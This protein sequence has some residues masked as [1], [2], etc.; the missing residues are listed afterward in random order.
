[1]RKKVVPALAVVVLALA[2]VGA[3]AFAAGG[4]RVVM[5]DACD[6]AS[7][8]EVIGEGTCIEGGHPSHVTFGEMIDSLIQHGEHP[9]WRFTPL[10]RVVHLG[11]DVQIDNVGGEFHTYS[12]TDEFGGGFV[13]ELNEILGLD[14]IADGCL[15]PPGPTNAFV[16]AQGMGS[17]ST[18][19]L[20]VGT[21]KFLC[22][23][24]PWMKGTL[25]VRN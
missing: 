3:S 9:G 15:L 7:F 24:H 14:E 19:A 5:K 17:I 16:P 4:P 6:P 1:M 2:A 11:Q 13:P 20:G 8:N 12:R 22:C 21:H 25:T 23:I 18:T 10:H